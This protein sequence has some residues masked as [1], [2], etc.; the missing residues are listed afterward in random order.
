MRNHFA[1]R[2]AIACFAAFFL[3]TAGAPPAEAG[4]A[5][6]GLSNKAKREL[7]A[8]GVN[9][10]LGDFTPVE[11]V[12]VGDGWTRHTFDAAGGDGPICVAGTDYSVYTRKGQT[13]RLLIFLQGGGACWE[14]FYE[15]NV[16]AEAQAPPANGTRPP[17]PSPIWS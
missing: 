10:Y 3:L 17:A 15:C 11:S 7:R 16:L 14:N 4:K 5:R 9:K 8:A 6:K 1:V 12:D 2:T 13:S